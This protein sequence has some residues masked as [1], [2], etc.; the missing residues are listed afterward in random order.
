MEPAS[1][2]E[3]TATSR[4]T[5]GVNYRAT[6]ERRRY[7]D[8]PPAVRAAADTAL[9]SPVVRAAAPVT[10]G[11]TRAYAGHVFLQDGRDAFL[12]ATGPELPIPVKALRREAQMLG[13]LGDRIPAV[14]LI[15]AGEADDGG[16]VL[17]LD[18][19]DGHLPGFPW[20]NDEVALVRDACER[21]ATLPSSTLDG[22]EP[23]RLVDDLLGDKRLQAALDGGLAMPT[24]LEHLPDWLPSGV[25]DV[26][27]LARQAQTLLV[28]DHLNHFD[29]RPDNLLIGRGA[30]EASDR[31]YILDWNWVTLGPAWCDWVGIIPTMHD[32][33][34]ELADLMA[35]S[36]LSREAAPDAID[37]FLAVIAIYMLVGLG[38]G[39]PHGTIA[40]LR[41]HQR[42][43][44]R[45]FLNSLATH[46]GWL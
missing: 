45:I 33:G 12:K 5:P 1:T 35:S 2:S 43:Y 46:R 40:A 31:A 8:L 27:D 42:Y 41:H 20:T 25:G 34:Y 6:S 39:P 13:A 29:L 38:E 9:G 26:L 24:S 10:S 32:Q 4:Y 36:P 37:A 16:Q 23:G 11:F 14:P 3:H 28:G 18:W 15:G 21:V 19:V 44:A 17:A 7:Q 22:L 30:G